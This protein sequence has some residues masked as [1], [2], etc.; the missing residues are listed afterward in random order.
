MNPQIKELFRCKMSVGGSVKF[1]VLKLIN[2]IEKLERLGFAIDGEPSILVPLPYSFS[3]FV[4]KF[5][6]NHLEATLSEL[7]NMLEAVEIPWM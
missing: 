4:M 6:M 5:N 1:H 7:F 3:Q 2:L